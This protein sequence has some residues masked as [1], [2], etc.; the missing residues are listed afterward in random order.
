MG[1]AGQPALEVGGKAVGRNDVEA[2]AGQD[3]HAR[4][5]RL[6]VQGRVRLEHADLGGD[7]QVVRPPGPE[8][9]TLTAEAAIE[10]AGRALRGDVKPGY[11]TPSS[12]Y[13]ADLILALAGCARSDEPMR[14]L[15]PARRRLPPMFRAA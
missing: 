15:E 11:Q 13:G 4:R 5:P 9:Y 12:A 14:D 3:H 10:I 6:A 8:G 2:D 7:V 1:G